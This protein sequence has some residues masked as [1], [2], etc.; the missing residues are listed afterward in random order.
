GSEGYRRAS[1]R[2]PGFHDG[3]VPRRWRAARPLL[4]HRDRARRHADACVRRRA[5][6]GGRVGRRRV[7]AV[8]RRAAPAGAAPGG[9]D[10][11]RAVAAKYSCGGCHVL[12]DGKG[13]A[14]GPD[15][16]LSARKLQTDWVRGFLAAPRAAGK[17]YPWR[18]WRMPG[19]ALSRDEV[20][21]MTRYLATVGR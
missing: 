4:P 16:R 1:D 8:A 21:A 13:G 17:I 9:P 14:V 19:L 7:R 12:D 11:G 20:D 15:L 18:V 2:C 6:P 10:R 3:R 5:V